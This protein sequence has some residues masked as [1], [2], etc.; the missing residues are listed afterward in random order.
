MTNT[1][2][3]SLSDYSVTDLLA[4]I[5]RTEEASRAAGAK[6]PEAE[7]LADLWRAATAELNSRPAA[8]VLAA[9]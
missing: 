6:S 9:V 5:A 7:A 8:E 2:P 3:F 4:L 1:K